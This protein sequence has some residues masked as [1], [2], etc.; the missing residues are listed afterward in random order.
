MG[1]HSLE[2]GRDVP[3]VDAEDTLLAS[4]HFRRGD[5][6]QVAVTP[7]DRDDAGKAK[8]SPAVFVLNGAPRI[9]SEPPEFSENEVYRYAI[10]A[11]DPD[12]DA[13][14]FSLSGQ[15][16]AGME[17][18]P[19][20]GVVIWTVIVPEQE[21]TYTFEVVAED[22]KGAK[23]IQTITMTSTPTGGQASDG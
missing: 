18:E 16:P 7:H 2:G 13:I 9:L 20:A 14:H 8:L 19:D 6:V 15:P 17:I 1:R 5:K 22:P 10:R 23:S 4:S 12:G 11:E 21:V 3:V